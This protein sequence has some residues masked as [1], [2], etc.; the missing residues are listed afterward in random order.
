V[1]RHPGV[2]VRELLLA[3]PEVAGLV[4]ARVYPSP[5]PQGCTLPAVTYQRVAGRS[6]QS[7]TGLSGCAMPRM[8]VDCWAETYDVA[9]EIAQAVKGWLVG[10]AGRGYQGTVDGVRVQGA[11]FLDDEDQYERDTKLHRV[12]ADYV[13]FHEEEV[14]WL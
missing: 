2:I 14:V 4:A 11:R 10:V 7:L 8:Q 5:L 1:K 13:V 9:Q 12:R 6:V 3:S